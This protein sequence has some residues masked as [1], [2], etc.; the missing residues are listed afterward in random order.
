MRIM[1]LYRA[2]ALDRFRPGDSYFRFLSHVFTDLAAA[3]NYLDALASL[4]YNTR[5]ITLTED[6][7]F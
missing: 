1:T 3:E 4:G 5:I 2:E 6:W 7:S